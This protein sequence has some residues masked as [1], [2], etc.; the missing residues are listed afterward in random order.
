MEYLVRECPLIDKNLAYYTQKHND[1][2]IEVATEF[3]GLYREWAWGSG[4]ETFPDTLFAS[5]SSPQVYLKYVVS[6]YIDEMTPDD[7]L[8]KAFSNPD[9]TAEIKL[10]RGVCPHAVI[11]TNY[12]RFI[13]RCFL[14]YR[15]IVGQ[16]VLRA[17][18]SSI[19]DI[20]KIHGCVSAP[21]SLV[22]TGEDYT[23]FQD[24][25]K[26]LNALLF[27]YFIEH[28]IFFLGYSANDPNIKAILT[29]INELL[30]PNGELVSNI[31]LVTWDGEAESRHNLPVE[32]LIPL[33]NGKRIRV[34]NIVANNFSWIYESLAHK[35]ALQNVNV[36]LLR[37]LLARVKQL[38]R[39]DIPSGTCKVDYATIEG[40]V[41]KEG[42]FETVFGISTIN[43]PQH[44]NFNYPYTLTQLQAKLKIPGQWHAA[45]KLFDKI[46]ETTGCAIEASDNQYHV[47]MRLGESTRRKYSEEAVTLLQRVNGGEPYLVNLLVK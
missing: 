2:L 39:S 47:Q 30:S 29:D 46:L 24:R 31:F 38:V 16:Q 13:E 33:G 14:N 19:G 43:D 12:D 34:K 7:D 18:H 35:S 25:L 10:F 1:N 8:T 40:M 27:A 28:P 23:L 15:C 22:L 42:E 41:E 9:T 4:R 45:R 44:I 17:D 3:A 6:K 37:N 20:Y 36:K 26:Y 32:E 5:G 21:D 11:T